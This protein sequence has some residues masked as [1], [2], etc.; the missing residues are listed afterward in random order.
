MSE[1]DHRDIESIV[2][3]LKRQSAE[4]LIRVS[5]HAHQEMVAEDI[6][7]EMIRK[8]L[9]DAHVVENY[10]EHKRGPCCLVCRD[11]MDGRFVHV[12]TTT[13][14]EVAVIITAYEPKQDKWVTPFERGKRS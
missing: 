11:M 12:V 5:V 10:P 2:G 1:A 6:S 7:Y 14:L 13:S 3:R 9:L 8:V 4:D